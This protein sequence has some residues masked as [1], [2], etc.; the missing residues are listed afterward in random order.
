[1]ERSD[2]LSGRNSLFWISRQIDYPLLP[3]DFV[4]VNFTFRCN[5][6][7]KMC[8]MRTQMEVNQKENKQTEIGT[9]LCKKIIRDTKELG[10]RSI[11]FLGG[12]PLL[13]GDLFDL[14]KYASDFGLE[15]IIVTNGVLLNDKNIKKCFESGVR[16]LSISLDA[17]SEK[18]FG[19]IRGQNIFN[20]IVNNISRLNELK[21]QGQR[22]F[23][24]VVVVCTVMDDNLEELVQVVELCE[25]LQVAKVLFQPVV[26]CNVDQTQRKKEFAGAIP[27]GR[28]GILD[29]TIS[30][31]VEYKKKASFNYSFLEWF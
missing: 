27:E 21:K 31:L 4:Q 29:E 5:L 8:D 25:R 16:W 30:K 23:P 18:T 10:T 12:E 11:I 3:P 9:E 15:P 7:C 22:E 1:M 24:K 17:A 13:R 14:I 28:L 19:Q 2:W 6:Q 26:A 20:T